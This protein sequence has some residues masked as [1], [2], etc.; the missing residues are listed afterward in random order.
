MAFIQSTTGLAGSPIR[1]TQMPK[2]MVRMMRG[3]TWNREIRRGRSPTVRVL[4]IWSAMV[5]GLAADWAAAAAGAVK[6]VGT[7]VK[8]V[9]RRISPPEM[10]AVRM[11]MIRVYP[12]IFPTFPVSL[13]L[14]MEPAM[15]KKI[16]GTMRQNSRFRK[17]CP[18][19]FRN[20]ALSPSTRPR[21]APR[22]Q[23]VIRIMGSR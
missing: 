19:G 22:M 18:M 3:S 21:M 4:T 8:W 2:K 11:K 10:V 23:K 13:V 9:T 5:T 6:E 17:I 7:P 12:I 15:E 20:E 1:D 16:S 14:A